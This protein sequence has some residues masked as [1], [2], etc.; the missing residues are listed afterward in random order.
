MPRTVFIIVVVFI[1]FL[2]SFVFAGKHAPSDSLG[3]VA[4]DT[5]VS[6]ESEEPQDKEEEH[7]NTPPYE[8]EHEKRMRSANAMITAGYILD[9]VGGL[10]AVGG[11]VMFTAN[12]SKRTTALIISSSG[13]AVGLTGG[14][15]TILG[16]H[17]RSSAENK[18]Q[19][20][21]L[22]DPESKTMGLAY[23]MRF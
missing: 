20:T 15:L 21:P 22:A 17:K 5:S 18:F 1:F 8:D 23:A 16:Y 11:S 7:P 4:A 14:L 19:V 3:S 9:F 10:T 12:S 2:P 6:D 13:L